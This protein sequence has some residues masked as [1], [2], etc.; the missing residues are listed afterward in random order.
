MFHRACLRDVMRASE[1]ADLA[2]AVQVSARV[3]RCIR[4]GQAFRSIPPLVYTDKHAYAWQTYIYIYI[5][6]NVYA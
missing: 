4:I 3:M 6:I 1:N 2:A 5:Y